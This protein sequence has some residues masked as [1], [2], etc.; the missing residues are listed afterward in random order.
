MPLRRGQ[1]W[2][3]GYAAGVEGDGEAIDW[4]VAGLLAPCVGPLV[5]CSAGRLLG[6]GAGD[7]AGGGGTLP[8]SAVRSVCSARPLRA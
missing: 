2:P 5:G 4:A 6:G 3:V 8:V 1:S 7:D